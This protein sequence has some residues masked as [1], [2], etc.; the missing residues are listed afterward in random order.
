MHVKGH[1][2]TKKL[3]TD[4]KILKIL[5]KYSEDNRKN[6]FITVIDFHG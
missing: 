1:I 4:S 3:P 5:E 2:I 6:K